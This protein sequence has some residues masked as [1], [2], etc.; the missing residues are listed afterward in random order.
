MNELC[1]VWAELAADPEN[2][3][4]VAAARAR[5]VDL[6]G[7]VGTCDACGL[8]GETMPF[9]ERVLA[10]LGEEN[11][12]L[13]PEE[14][15]ELRQLNQLLA[16]GPEAIEAGVEFLLAGLP[17]YLGSLPVDPARIFQAIEAV[18][19]LVRS[20]G[21]MPSREAA[22]REIMQNADVPEAVAESLWTWQ[23]EVVDR[24]PTLYDSTPDL[25]VRWQMPRTLRS[26]EEFLFVLGDLKEAVEAG[27]RLLEAK[28]PEL[29]P[30]FVKQIRSENAK[31]IEMLAP[32]ADTDDEGRAGQAGRP[33]HR[34]AEREGGTGM[35]AVVQHLRTVEREKRRCLSAIANAPVAAIGSSQIAIAFKTFAAKSQA[36]AARNIIELEKFVKT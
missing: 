35:V 21:V 22:V 33:A 11:L 10:V 18:A 15:E 13:P 17:E 8:I 34:S 26:N 24:C 31:I 5:L 36:V 4:A 19:R 1:R 27:T 29:S 30:S 7:H 20:N 14:L 2:A 28:P 3:S 6:I 25:W 12:N 16:D 32:L 9:P 23:L